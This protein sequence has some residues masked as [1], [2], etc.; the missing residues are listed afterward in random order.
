M[1]K[2]K[3][4]IDIKQHI[5]DDTSSEAIVKAAKA[6][7]HELEK[8]PGWLIGYGLDEHI[9]DF[10]EIV[11]CTHDAEDNADLLDHF[12]YLLNDLYSFADYNRIWMGFI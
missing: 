4:S 7:V 3:Y 10:Q 1:T 6:I 5:S 8:L 2:W 12:N 9:Y 11:D